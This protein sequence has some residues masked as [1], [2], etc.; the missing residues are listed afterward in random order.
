MTVDPDDLADR[1]QTVSRAELQMENREA[2]G[3]TADVADEIQ[4]ILQ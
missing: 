2:M 3:D 1:Q 4:E